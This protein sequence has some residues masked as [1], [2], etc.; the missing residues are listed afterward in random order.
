MCVCGVCVGCVC[1]LDS[2]GTD[3]WR[4]FE[5]NLKHQLSA[6]QLLNNDCAPY[7][8]L[9]DNLILTYVQH[10]PHFFCSVTR[11]AACV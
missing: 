8:Q 9:L 5:K 10:S 4:Y 11:S 6:C 2:C 3:Q 7:G 1:E